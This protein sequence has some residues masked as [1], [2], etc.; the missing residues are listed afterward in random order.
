MRGGTYEYLAAY[1]SE[2]YGSSSGFETDPATTYG[3][4]Y[5]DVYNASSTVTSYSYRILGDATGEMGPFK[6]YADSDGNS[7]YHNSWYADYSY[8]VESSKPWFERGGDFNDGVLAGLF[9]FNRHTGG[10]NSNISFRL[11]LAF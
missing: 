3:S 7:R 8:F 11:V 9:L 2:N 10:A 1:I 6:L 5:F 4:K